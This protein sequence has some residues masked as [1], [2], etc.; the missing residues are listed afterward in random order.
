[1]GAGRYS[2]AGAE[3]SRARPASPATADAATRDAIELRV[4]DDGIG[5]TEPQ[6][7][8][9]F[10]MARS[11]VRDHDTAQE[12]SANDYGPLAMSQDIIARFGPLP[13]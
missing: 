12:W 7:R 3:R 13:A 11:R 1:M 6:A 4:E 8:S 2:G 9:I 10:A 5:L